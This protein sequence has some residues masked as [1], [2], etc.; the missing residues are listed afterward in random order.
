VFLV[1]LQFSVLLT[2]VLIGELI[3]AGVTY[4]V[5]SDIEQFAVDQMNHSMTMYNKSAEATTAWDIL[6]SDVNDGLLLLNVP[7]LLVMLF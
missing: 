1:V 4:H 3:L 2:I 7:T 6:Q 5:R